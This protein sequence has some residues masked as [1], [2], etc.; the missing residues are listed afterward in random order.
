MYFAR[1]WP[2]HGQDN[3]WFYTFSSPLPLAGEVVYGGR[4][5]DMWDRRC[6]VSTLRKFYCEAVT[7]PGHSF[8]SDGVY[9]P[10]LASST[11]NL[12]GLFLLGNAV[13]SFVLV[14]VRHDLFRAQTFRAKLA[15]SAKIR[16]VHTW[17][18]IFF[19]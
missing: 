9:R 3:F 1:F 7:V 14:I 4:V 17:A 12:V 8:S 15:P 13:L 19:F 16:L 18:W 5:T 2:C 10:P 6:L 11:F